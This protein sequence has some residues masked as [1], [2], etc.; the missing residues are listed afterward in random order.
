MVN[1]GKS[2]LNG[3]DNVTQRF[4]PSINATFYSVLYSDK[5]PLK[6]SKL[7]EKAILEK[8]LTTAKY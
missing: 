7:D 6:M 8:N 2:R 3:F 1:R 4:A 5:S